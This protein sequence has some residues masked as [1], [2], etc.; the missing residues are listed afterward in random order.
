MPRASDYRRLPGKAARYVAVS[1]P[2]KGQEISKRAHD[3]LRAREQGWPSRDAYL[4]ARKNSEYQRHLEQYAKE[5]KITEKKARRL[6]TEFNKLFADAYVRPDG[7]IKS[8]RQA[9]GEALFW[10]LFAEGY[11]TEDDFNRYV[12]G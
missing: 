10:L 7:T 4:A 8:R 9:D 6:G 2:E 5:N 3:N 11:V 1:G 12:N